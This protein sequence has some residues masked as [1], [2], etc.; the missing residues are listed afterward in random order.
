MSLSA[1]IFDLDGLLIDTE[2]ASKLAW[3]QTAAA[4]GFE[5]PEA[6]YAQIAGTTV[7]SAK[8]LI[9]N[10]FDKL[11]IEAYMKGSSTKY[12]ELL[13]QS[14]IHAMTGAREMLNFLK[15]S[16]IEV[17]VATSS[18]RSAARYK[19]EQAD[20]SDEFSIVVSGEDVVRGK[21]EPDLF[22]LTAQLLEIPTI[23]C[24]VIEDAEP[25][26]LGAHRA[27]MQSIMVPST[28]QPSHFV[29]NIAYSIEPTLKEVIPILQ[30]LINRSID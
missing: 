16:S 9:A 2:N 8:K 22:V 18:T 7:T 10:T 12:Y 11:D 14:G 30:K 25:G 26:I 1:V 4:F 5:F 28:T 13:D 23:E 6:L 24:M 17:A 3:M 20:L 27:G 21:P 19:L 29:K 15:R